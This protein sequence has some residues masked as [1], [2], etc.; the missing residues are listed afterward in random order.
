MKTRV[1]GATGLPR[2]LSDG[3]YFAAPLVGAVIIGSDS[4]QASL[5]RALEML[6]ASTLVSTVALP[7]LQ[8]HYL[9]VLLLAK[10][11][12]LVA[13][14]GAG[15]VGRLRISKRISIVLLTPP[16]PVVNTK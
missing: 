4:I 1:S 12:M 6:D 10:A 7:D 5:I 16:L 13:P 9:T 15:R 3:L 2:R 14:P 8:R 11:F